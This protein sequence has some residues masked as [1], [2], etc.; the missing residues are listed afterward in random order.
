MPAKQGGQSICPPTTRRAGRRLSLSAGS[1]IDMH[2]LLGHELCVTNS[3]FFNPL[4]RSEPA[5]ALPIA[6]LLTRS[7]GHQ[8]TM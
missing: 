5:E 7:L 4:A 6:H 2:A 1:I 3:L 8:D